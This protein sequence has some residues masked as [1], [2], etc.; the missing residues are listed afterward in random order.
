MLFFV[1]KFRYFLSSSVCDD[2]PHKKRLSEDMVQV[3]GFIWTISYVK[4]TEL[5]FWHFLTLIIEIFS[6]IQA[7]YLN[8]VMG[9]W[10][11]LGVFC[12]S[13]TKISIFG[14]LLPMKTYDF[15]KIEFIWHHLQSKVS[16]FSE[17]RAHNTFIRRIA[18]LCNQDLEM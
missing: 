7:T 4:W 2:F 1:D 12:T 11:F 13:R 6:K 18:A 3:N 15:L 8:F 9:K 5:L 10:P 17:Y 14:S 16:M